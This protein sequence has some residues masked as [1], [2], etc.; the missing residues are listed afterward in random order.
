MIPIYDV[1][2]FIERCARSIFEQTYKDIEYIFIDDCSPDRS[3]DILKSVLED[4]PKRKEDVHIIRHNKN[5]GLAAARNTSIEHA[6][7]EFIY[8]VDSDDYLEKDTIKRL[9]EKQQ[10]SQADIVSGVT[11]QHLRNKTILIKN[12]VSLDKQRNVEEMLR[13]DRIYNHLITNKL[14]RLDLYKKHGIRI[15]EGINQGE[16]W[17]IMP[18]LVYYADKMIS[19]DK[20]TYHYDCTNS[21]SMSRQLKNCNENLWLQ[22]IGSQKVLVDFFSN[23]ESSLAHQAKNTALFVMS[24]YLHRSAKFGRKVFFHNLL[25]E[26]K[27]S[28]KENYAE[29]GWD[30]M[31]KRGWDS[32][33]WGRRV[34]YQSRSFVWRHVKKYIKK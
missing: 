28:Y 6:K 3:I 4:Y 31:L 17:Q 8:F 12:A 34:F 13:Y 33:Y 24:V 14:I 25:K 18:Q 22:D 19:I 27:S 9:V 7:G 32:W 15:K 29:I 23:R 11:K 10:E 26:M 30:N 2:F 1:E 16:D 20:I 5:R 21:N